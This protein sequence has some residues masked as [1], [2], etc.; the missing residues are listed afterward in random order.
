MSERVVQGPA[1][2]Q[3]PT[4]DPILWTTRLF[5]RF[6]QVIFGTFDKGNYHWDPDLNNTEIIV[7]DQA[8][9]NREVV[10]KRPAIVTQRGDMNFMNVSMDQFRSFDPSTGRREHTDLAS[11]VMTFNC[12]STEGLEAQRIAW[13]LAYAIR[14]LK[15][16]LMQAGL[17]RVGEDV[18]VGK[19]SPPGA[20]VPGVANNEI[21]LV[22]VIVP[23]YF[24]WTWTVEP[25]NKVLLKEIDLALTS[26]LDD[27][28]LAGSA[29][30]S[31]P[32][33]YGK[34]IPI[35][36]TYSLT[37]KARVTTSNTPKPRK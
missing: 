5:V 7:S 21:V 1:Q 17:H 23:Y 8:T 31:A 28:N 14:T 18:M 2:P 26:G 24:Q 20:V 13:A 6:A 34:P 29:S 27:Q 33:I 25:V 4:E 37:E 16:S 35:G 15:R 22:P 30:I 9:I 32:S 12:L 10:Q 36:Q 11:S 19:E 3:G